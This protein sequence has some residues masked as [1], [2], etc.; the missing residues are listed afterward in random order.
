MIDDQ[1]VDLTPIASKP[2][3]STFTLKGLEKDIPIS[4]VN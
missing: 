1:N 3:P 2:Q 4:E